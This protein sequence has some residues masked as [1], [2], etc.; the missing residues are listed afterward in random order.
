MR[1]NALVVDLTVVGP[2]SWEYLER[3]CGR[4]PGLAVVV[5]T[6]PSSVAHECVACGSAP[7]RG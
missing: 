1:L 7:T 6:G 3:V 5:C 2:D 4:L